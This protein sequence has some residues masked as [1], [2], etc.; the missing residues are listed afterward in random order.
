MSDSQLWLGYL[1]RGEI[2]GRVLMPWL[3]WSREMPLSSTMRGT[4]SPGR[5]E[6]RASAL[7]TEL[8]KAVPRGGPGLLQEG[9]ARAHGLKGRFSLDTDWVR[10]LREA[11]RAVIG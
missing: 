6:E 2:H 4:E 9:R 10:V 1:K 8:A 5:G 11:R 7:G 3:P